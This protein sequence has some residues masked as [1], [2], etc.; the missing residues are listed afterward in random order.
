V[1]QRPDAPRPR[2]TTMGQ[3]SGGLSKMQIRRDRGRGTAQEQTPPQLRGIHN[4]QDVGE[5]PEKKEK[6]R[7]KKKKTGE[8]ARE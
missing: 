4:R 5:T 8:Q 3:T 7:F 1:G 6:T 2:G